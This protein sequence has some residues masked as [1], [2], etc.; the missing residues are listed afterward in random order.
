MSADAGMRRDAGL[1]RRSFLLTVAAG[2]AGAV[3]Y[4][5]GRHWFSSG[6]PA[7]GPW[8]DWLLDEYNRKAVKRLGGAYR[9]AH[10]LERH[11]AVLADRIDAA[12]AAEAGAGQTV[13]DEAAM[14]GLLQRR[15]RHEYARDEV[16][17]VSGW[18]L[19]ITEARLYALVAGEM[20]GES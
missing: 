6:G 8:S 19:S 15:V 11:N 17:W 13:T 5:A 3:F 12:L 20:E 2:A 7:G 4:A 1:S 18:I 16:V 14:V 9:A 10:L